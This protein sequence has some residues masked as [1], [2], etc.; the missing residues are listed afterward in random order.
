MSDEIQIS[1]PASRPQPSASYSF[2][3]RLH[4]PQHGSA[5][6][7]VSHALAEAE[8]IARRRST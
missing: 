3:M 2:T 6:A 1:P 4:M 7:R 5:F 8:A